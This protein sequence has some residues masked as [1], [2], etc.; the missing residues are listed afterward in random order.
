MLSTSWILH[1]AVIVTDVA[2]TPWIIFYLL[3]TYDLC[4]TPYVV[5]FSFVIFGC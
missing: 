1:F 4:A 5:E 3:S 2:L